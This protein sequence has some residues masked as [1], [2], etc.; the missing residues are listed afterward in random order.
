MQ[1]QIESPG[2]ETGEKLINLIRTKFDHLGKRYE[3]INR[4]D[5]LLKKV[6][7]DKKKYFFIEAKMEVPRRIL[8]ASDNAESF[9]AALDK[10]IHDLEH[11]LN[12]HKE[13]I[14]EVR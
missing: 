9:E 3:R 13:E 12:R 5:V 4:C 6:K 1:I 11:Q 7:S 8:F 2:I 14:E 10:V